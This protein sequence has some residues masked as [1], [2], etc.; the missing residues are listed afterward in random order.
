MLTAGAW[1]LLEILEL[2][3]TTAGPGTP[4]VTESSSVKNKLQLMTPTWSKPGQPKK[5][6]NQHPVSS[7]GAAGG[8]GPLLPAVAP[9]RLPPLELFHHPH[10]LHVD[11]PTITSTSTTSTTTSSSTS[12][13]SSAPHQ[14]KIKT[15]PTKSAYARLLGLPQCLQMVGDLQTRAYTSAAPTTTRSPSLAA[16]SLSLSGDPPKR[17][18]VHQTASNQKTTYAC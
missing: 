4:L 1:G 14:K 6:H 3:L 10:V 15:V 12:T 7:G 9:V 8:R 18:Q 2:I 11:R 5:K 13:S 16:V 17:N